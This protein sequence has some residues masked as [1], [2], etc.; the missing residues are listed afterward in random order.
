M[1]ITLIRRHGPGCSAGHP[2]QSATTEAEERRKN[3]RR[4]T[5]RIYAGGTLNGIYH[6]LATKTR[7]WNRARE[8]V[9]PYLEAGR[10][11]ITPPILPPPVAP[12][13]S[14][15]APQTG[16]P[17]PEA[18]K[19]YLKEHSDA[20]SAAGTLK[21]Y[22]QVL[23]QFARYAEQLGIRYIEEW[24]RAHTRQFRATWGNSALTSDKKLS[25]LKAFFAMFV[26]DEVLE[27][28][29]ATISTRKNR[30]FKKG[31]SEGGRQ[32]NPFTGEELER[33]LDGCRNLDKLAG[34][35]RW[36][37]KKDGRQVVA[38]T[39]YRDYRRKWTGEDLADFIQ[40]SYF[41]GL[42]ISDVATFD[43]SRLTPPGEVK[44]RATKNGEWVSVWIPEW[45]RNLIRARAARIGPLIFGTHTTTDINV[46]TDV[47]RRKLNRLWL[48]AGPWKQK[49]T[50]H[51]FRHTFVRILLERQVPISVIADL[52]G[53]TE[54]M[55]EKHYSAWMPGRQQ[56]TSRILAEAFRD[57][58]RFHGR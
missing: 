36:P 50:H 52:T 12:P 14:A 40:I 8:V 42:R 41:T 15:S 47:W 27:T 32:K 45:L 7:D 26:E 34:L 29:P 39:Q 54:K 18:I 58:P 5:C 22:R 33:M 53:D 24:K 20:K 51:R 44:L 13:P 46:I 56:E 31:E 17:V 23:G 37:K 6:K 35:R 38:I 1:S 4:C 49:P 30:A 2:Q 43:V 25:C 55:I 16:T 57:V 9:A 28:N 11:D 21:K 48:G 19:A 3:A 10:W